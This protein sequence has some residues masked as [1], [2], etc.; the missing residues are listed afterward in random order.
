MATI[1]A[2]FAGFGKTE[3]ATEIAL[4][5]QDTGEQMAA[6]SQIA[7]ILTVQKEDDLARQT[8]NLIDEDADRLFAIAAE[9]IRAVGLMTRKTGLVKEML[10]SLF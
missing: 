3:K 8:L 4:E 6:L 9:H 7:Q 1:A 10:R 2:Q 5:N